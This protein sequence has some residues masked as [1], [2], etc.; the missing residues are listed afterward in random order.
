M[1]RRTRLVGAQ[2]QQLGQLQGVAELAHRGAGDGDLERRQRADRQDC[3]V[4]HLV[5]D[6]QGRS[7]RLPISTASSPWTTTA[8]IR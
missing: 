6:R 8:A 3:R 7:K 2:A 1:T 5:D 4:R